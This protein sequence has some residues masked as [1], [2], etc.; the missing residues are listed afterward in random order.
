VG[1]PK[2]I[3]SVRGLGRA[4]GVEDAPIGKRPRNFLLGT[5]IWRKFHALPG[6]LLGGVIPREGDDGAVSLLELKRHP[7]GMQDKY[8]IWRG[9][10]ELVLSA[11]RFLFG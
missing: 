10:A 4:V 6:L 7:R 5:K 3:T 2:T 11:G 1:C 8:N 9:P